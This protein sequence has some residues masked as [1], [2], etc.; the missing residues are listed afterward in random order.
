MDIKTKL[1]F[2]LVGLEQEDTVHL[3]LELNA[4]NLPAD[5]RR[6]PAQLQVVL[7]RSGSMADG[8]L[9]HALRAIDS[10]ILRLSPEDRFGLVGIAHDRKG[11]LFHNYREIISL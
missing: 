1:D 11:D 3:L 2:N 4:P 8:R 9:A 6:G 10:L 7:D 5:R